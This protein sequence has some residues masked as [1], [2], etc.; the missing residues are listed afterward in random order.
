[1][2]AE[3]LIDPDFKVT[4]KQYCHVLQSVKSP[5]SVI[6]RKEIT[7]DDLTKVRQF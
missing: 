5:T 4:A 1:M 7:V 3:I 2:F 6:L